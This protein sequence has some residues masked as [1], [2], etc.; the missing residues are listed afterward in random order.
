MPSGEL[1]EALDVGGKG[2]TLVLVGWAHGSDQLLD[3]LVGGVLEEVLEHL[4]ELRDV[5]VPASVLVVLVEQFLDLDHVRVQEA[6]QSYL[7]RVLVGH[8]VVDGLHLRL[9]QGAVHVQDELPEFELRQGSAPVRIVAVEE[10]L[11]AQHVALAEFDEG[12][13]AAA[14]RVDGL[15]T[16]LDIVVVHAWV[17]LAQQCLQLGLV[18]ASTSIRVKL[19]EDPEVC[20]QA[21]HQELGERD[22]AAVVQ[23]GML[24]QL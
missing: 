21:I 9:R 5:Q 22:V 6:A 10:R 23:V 4:L 13:A 16:L 17:Q 19:V 15:I 20:Q 7:A 12:D 8:Q 14:V 1:L 11:R 3:I 18:E 2:N 24:V